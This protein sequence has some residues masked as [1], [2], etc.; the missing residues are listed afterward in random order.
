MKKIEFLKIWLMLLILLTGCS[1]EY[2]GIKSGNYSLSYDYGNVQQCDLTI[3][4][5]SG[6]LEFS[7]EVICL[8]MGNA[9]RLKKHLFEDYQKSYDEL[10]CVDEQ[11]NKNMMKYSL[12]DQIMMLGG[13]TDRGSFLAL[14]MDYSLENGEYFYKYYVERC[15]NDGKILKTITL[16]FMNPKDIDLPIA[17]I[18]NDD[19]VFFAWEKCYY[20][21]SNKGEFQVF[22]MPSDYK[23]YRF[24]LLPDGKAA[25]DLCC[26]VQKNGDIISIKHIIMELGNDENNKNTI[27]EYDELDDRMDWLCAANI[28]YDGRV[29]LADMEGIYLADKERKNLCKIFD[30][31]ENGFPISYIY[32]LA[33]DNSGTIFILIESDKIPKLLVL[34]A[35]ERH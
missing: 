9:Y 10:V 8:G 24:I 6:E 20:E 11:L 1:G 18:A 22:D 29:I 35:Y 12:N 15:S 27:M 32:N 16:D 14:K 13:T 23:F 31:K 2:K 34:K 7:G 28:Y 30:W 26:I 3:E 21:I 4:K 33:S 19:I 25:M 5:I 17:I